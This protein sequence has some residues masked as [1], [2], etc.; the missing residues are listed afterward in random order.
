VEYSNN[1]TSQDRTFVM[2]SSAPVTVPLSFGVSKN[3]KETELHSDL[4]LCSR[5]KRALWVSLTQF[6][7]EEQWLGGRSP[8]NRPRR[9]RGGA[10]V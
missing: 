8:D 7:M 2:Y 4:V 6:L 1:R 10:E 5:V 3:R 9:A